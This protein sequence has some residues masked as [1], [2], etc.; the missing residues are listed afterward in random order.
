MPKMPRIAEEISYQRAARAYERTLIPEK[1][2]MEAPA[3]ATQ[4]E[5][6]VSSLAQVHGVRPDVQYFN[7]LLVQYQLGK[8]RKIY[9]VVPDNM[10]VVCEEPIVIDNGSFVVK[11]QPARPFWMLEYVSKNNERKDYEHNFDRYEQELKVPYYLIFYPDNQ[12]LSL[13]RLREGRYHS[14]TANREG[15]L[16]IPKLELE[17]G[18]LEGWVRFWFRG[19]LLLLPAALNEALLQEKQAR[20]A[21]EERLALVERENALLRARIEQMLSQGKS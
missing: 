9:N 15:R 17:L 14:V 5:I 21:A 7:E 3:Q 4:R 16:A 2:L 11:H 6:T 8:E 10:V 18:I 19:E 20:K 12:E 1:D 13:F